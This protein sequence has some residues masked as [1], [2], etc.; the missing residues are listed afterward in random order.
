MNG[1]MNKEYYKNAFSKVC[2]SEE[3]IERMLCMTDTRKKTF[4]HKGLIIVLAVIAVLVCGTFTVNAATDG[5]LFGKVKIIINGDEV[6]P[7]EHI[8]N[9]KTYVD[10]EGNKITSF[11]V[12]SPDGSR[13]SF[14]YGTN[15]EEDENLEANINVNDDG[16][17]NSAEISV[18]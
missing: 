9:Y 5:A 12:E 1:T 6:N 4:R 14:S 7:T 8:K 15:D 18:E 3:A 13:Q 17:H 11:E 2:P 16:T 10:D